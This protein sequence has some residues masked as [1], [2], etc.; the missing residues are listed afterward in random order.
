MLAKLEERDVP[1][2]GATADS[3][4]LG[5]GD[6]ARDEVRQS[7]VHVL[8]FG[9]ADVPDQG[10]SPLASVPDRTAVVD[11][12]DDEAGVDVRLHLRLPAIEVV[13]GGSPVDEHEHGERPA[14]VVRRHEEAVHRL[15]VW[16]LEMP[17]LVR[18]GLRCPPAE[19]ENLC[20]CVVED[21]PL[22]MALLVQEPHAAVRPHAR[23][24]DVAWLAGNVRQ[25]AVRD[26]V[27]VELRS[28]L[29]RVH[30]QERRRIRPPVVHVNLTVELDVQQRDLPGLEVPQRRTCVAFAL[31]LEGKPLISGD[32]RPA[33]RG[34]RHSLVEQVADGRSGSRIQDA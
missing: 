24:R 23:A 1:A 33:L 19:V 25:L 20:T 10:V 29:E 32:R 3:G 16:V 28:P 34:Q 27:A 18:A 11:H 30:E 13:P 2:P 21:E 7:R 15:P 4:S 9:P 12:P 8:E 5:I 14:R 26:V 31:V 22:P 6:A 17:G